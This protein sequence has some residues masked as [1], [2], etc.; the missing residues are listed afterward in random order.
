MNRKI[1]E[2]KLI[3]RCQQVINVG[4]TLF[5]EVQAGVNPDMRQAQ[6]RLISTL[7]RVKSYPSKSH[8]EL[9]PLE[10][11][12]ADVILKLPD[13]Q[14]IPG[15]CHYLLTC[16]L[17]EIFVVESLW[18]RTWNEQKL[19]LSIYGTNDRAWRFWDYVNSPEAGQNRCVMHVVLECILHGFEG[20]MTDSPARLRN[21]FESYRMA[22]IQKGLATWTPPPDLPV[23]ANVPALTGERML[24]RSIQFA[25]ATGT[26]LI[27][28]TS[29]LIIYSFRN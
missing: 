3:A 29:F 20:Q 8:R 11:A 4:M 10:S 25:L 22:F 2:E 5:Q 6:S 17:D 7:G 19:E 21:W 27:P 15:V 13:F 9:S 28:L 1:S 14:D 26:V 24:E 18:S 12:P 23:I 16:W